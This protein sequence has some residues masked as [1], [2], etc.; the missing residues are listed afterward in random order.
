MTQHES[1][2]YEVRAGMLRRYSFAP[3]SQTV[4]V[5]QAIVHEHYDRSG[6]SIQL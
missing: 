4:R 6:M 1:H 3:M 5:L 2:Y